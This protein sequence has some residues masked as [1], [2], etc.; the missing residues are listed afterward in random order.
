MSEDKYLPGFEPINKTAQ[1]GNG[2]SK[3][4][5]GFEPVTAP[6]GGKYLEGFEPVS[7]GADSISPDISFFDAL[8][9]TIEPVSDNAILQGL[10][11]VGNTISIPTRLLYAGIQS[12]LTNETF[13][14]ALAKKTEAGRVLFG[15]D[16]GLLGIGADILLD[17]MNFISGAGLVKGAKKVGKFLGAADEFSDIEK[18]LAKSS[19]VFKRAEDL[20]PE[21]KRTPLW[22]MTEDELA[23]YK[24]N[25]KAVRPV[26]DIEKKNAEIV[27]A[28]YKENER[29]IKESSKIKPREIYRKLKREWVD[30]SGNVKTWLLK[31]GGEYGREAVIK[32]D[33]VAGA[34]SE[35][36]ENVTKAVDKIYGDLKPEE[37]SMLDKIINSRRTHIISLYKQ[38]KVKNPFNVSGFAH[39]DYLKELPASVKKRLFPK[40]EEYFNE[41]RKYTKELYDEGLITK[42]ELKNLY[43]K[44]YSPRKF[45][46]HIDPFK[47]YTVNGKRISVSDSGIEALKEGSFGALETNSRLLLSEVVSRVKTRIAKNKANKALYKMAK[48]N[49]G[50]GFVKIIDPNAKIPGGLEK[51][52]V[53]INGEKKSLLMTSEAAYEWVRNN[54]QINKSLANAIGWATGAKLLK[55]SA[56]GL[57]P[58]FF[59]SNFPRDIAHALLVTDEYSTA[60][61]KAIF[62]IAKDIKTVAKDAIFKKGSYLDYIKDGG[63]MEFLTHQGRLTKGT[64]ALAKFQDYLSYLGET[65]ESMVRLAIRNRA[66]RNGKSPREATWIARNYI[67]F[68]QGGSYAKA[69]DSGI[70]YLNAAIQGTRGLFKAASRNPK[71]FAAKLGQLGAFATGLYMYNSSNKEAF[72]QVPH[73]VKASNWVIT[74]PFYTTDDNGEKKYVY[75][76]IPKDQGQRALTSMF[77][78]LTAK[79]V[80]DKVDERQLQQSILDAFPITPEANLPPIVNAMLGYTA[81]I[82]FW[83]NERIWKG[84]RV[85]PEKEITKYTGDFYKKVGGATGLSPERLERSAGK[86]ISPYNPMSQLLGGAWDHLFNEMDEKD[87]KAFVQKLMTAPFM[88]RI[89]GVG[90][91]FSKYEMEIEKVKVEENTRRLELNSKIDNMDYKSALNYIRS[92]TLPRGDKMR[93]LQRA[94]NNIRFDGVKEKRYWVNI[95]KLAPEIR[96]NV[97]YTRFKEA[98]KQEQEELM[99]IAKKTKIATKRFVRRFNYLRRTEK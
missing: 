40:A 58:S 12:G 8:G 74:T 35:A 36:A 52:N 57:N 84:A 47:T 82:D 56:T 93:L 43:T 46:Q 42:D 10:E 48:E 98:N 67:D 49:P 53:M 94:K 89:A 80:G 30:T 34:T 20:T 96:A 61:P 27:E 24:K 31:N 87:K 14:Q 3:Y 86:I 44:D 70:P 18:V 65:S 85:Q 54:P 69:L 9:K 64:G 79:A 37:I 78:A 11:Y 68:S 39:A 32:K 28:M 1:K 60:L 95:S 66:L 75:L 17:P 76:K 29:M 26:V 62:Q 41:M 73:Y 83:R 15:E 13:N 45:M 22:K 6:G 21:I 72:D 71:K 38:G 4:L 16:A 90:K 19:R 63:G 97:F 23:L 99:R 50:N 5:T 25:P 59:I 2:G 88:R 51:V 81:N 7:G 92:S 77:D 55:A 33:L 91:P